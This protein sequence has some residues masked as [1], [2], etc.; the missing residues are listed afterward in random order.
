MKKFL[1]IL[2]LIAIF[3]TPGCEPE[4]KTTKKTIYEDIKFH[5]R[6]M[7]GSEAV[8]L[9]DSILLESQH[10]LVLSVFKAYLSNIKARNSEDQLILLKDVAL[11]S[12]GDS[13]NHTFTAQVPTGHYQELQI[14]FGLNAEQNA[15]DPD[16]YPQDHPLATYQSMYWSMLKYRFIK[17]E[18]WIYTN[19]MDKDTAISYHTGTDAL[20]QVRHFNESF[21]V[22]EAEVTQLQVEIDIN[23]VFDGPAGSIDPMQEPQTHSTPANFSVA[24]RLMENMAESAKIQVV[25][26]VP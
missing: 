7:N 4:K 25:Y 20:Y 6:L 17:M 9:H 8:E 2:L 18:G 1:S 23:K 10:K 5:V 19:S 13:L 16:S 24:S 11:I 12:L 15:S 14:G 3:T 21:N 26:T 22:S